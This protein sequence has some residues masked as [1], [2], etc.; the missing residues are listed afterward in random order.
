MDWSTNYA[1][2]VIYDAGWFHNPASRR[3]SDFRLAGQYQGCDM[4]KFRYPEDLRGAARL[5][6]EQMKKMKN[7]K[8]KYL[9]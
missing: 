6:C 1:Y 4:S 8:V 7:L 9:C 5:E 2:E 3:F